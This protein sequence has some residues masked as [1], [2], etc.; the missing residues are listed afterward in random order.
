M[1]TPVCIMYILFTKLFQLHIFLHQPL[2]SYNYIKPHDSWG[3]LALGWM[4][5]HFS[6]VIV[7]VCHHLSPIKSVSIPA[8]FKNTS[9]P[10]LQKK[11]LH[12]YSSAISLQLCFLCP[13]PQKQWIMWIMWWH[14]RSRNEGYKFPNLQTSFL[15]P[16][17]VTEAFG[18]T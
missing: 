15:I 2:P 7:D 16:F 6:N 17:L 3:L 5:W 11:H 9:A 10:V 14:P 1:H 13:C 4:P 8:P 18:N 12:H